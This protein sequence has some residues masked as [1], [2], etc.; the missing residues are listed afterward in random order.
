VVPGPPAPVTACSVAHL[1]LGWAG[2]VVGAAT[3][4]GAAALALQEDL[5][6]GVL[7]YGLLVSVV[8]LWSVAL[9]IVLWR[10]AASAPDAAA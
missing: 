1:W 2:L 7:L 5:F 6:A 4:A 9:G 8:Q 10:R 3:V